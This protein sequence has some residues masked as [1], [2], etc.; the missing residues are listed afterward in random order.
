MASEAFRYDTTKI[1]TI[2][3]TLLL[4]KMDSM[5]QFSGTYKLSKITQGM[6]CISGKIRIAPS[7]IS[8]EELVHY[9]TGETSKL[10]HFLNNFGD[11]VLDSN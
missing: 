7:Q 1:P 10:K 6:C 5:F 8:P 2:T 9:M 3:Y 4:E 11:K